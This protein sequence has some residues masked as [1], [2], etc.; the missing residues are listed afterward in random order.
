MKDSTFLLHS[1][2]APLYILLTKM[3]ALF[4]N[5]T[6]FEVRLRFKIST[7]EI[8]TVDSSQRLSSE[9]TLLK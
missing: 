6:F 3:H 1:T 9:L 4:T 2:A 7:V 8:M 5:T